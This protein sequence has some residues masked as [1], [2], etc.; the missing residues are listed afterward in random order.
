MPDE[1]L[2]IIGPGE[3][4]GTFTSFV[5]LV[6]EE[7]TDDRGQDAT[8]RPDYQSSADDNVIIQGILG[9]DS[10]LGWVGFAFAHEADDVKVLPIAEEPGGECVEPTPETIAD[11]S[12]PISRP[13]FIYVNKAKAESNPALAAFVD[14]YL[15]DAISSVSDVGY[16]D[17]SS[18]DLAATRRVWDARETGPQ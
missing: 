17:L 11:G 16:V 9:S 10:S 5:E 14:F 12:Y 7:F 13:L 18:D 3:E 1:P 6:I 8:T 2:D 15:H 4:S